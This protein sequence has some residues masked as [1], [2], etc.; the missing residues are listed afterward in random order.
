MPMKASLYGC[1][2]IIRPIGGLANNFD[3]TNAIVVSGE[4]VGEA[5]RRAVEIWQDEQAMESLR[6]TA[7]NRDFGWKSR[8]RPLL[9]MC[10]LPMLEELPVEPS[11]S[12]EPVDL[13]TKKVSPFAVKKGG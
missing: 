9:E 12:V 4:D 7:Q 1:V 5:V 6:K 8:M 2:P 3:E 13:T 10:G 11:I